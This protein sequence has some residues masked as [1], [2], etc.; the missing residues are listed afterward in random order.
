MKDQQVIP[1]LQTATLSSSADDYRDIIDD[2]TMEIQK[3]EEELKMYKQDGPELL[4]E[5]R[6]FEITIHGLPEK[7]QRE[8]RT[9]LEA[10]AAGLR[11]FPDAASPQRQC[12]GSKDAIQGHIGSGLSSKHAPS[13]LEA[14]Q[15]P[16]DSAYASISPTAISSA[17]PIGKPS[18]GAKTGLLDQNFQHHLR[19]ISEG[20]YPCPTI[21][22]DE[23]K[24]QLVVRRLEQLFSGKITGR[25]PRRVPPPSREKITH[26]LSRVTLDKQSLHHSPVHQPPV[27]INQP[28]REARMLALPQQ[29][30]SQQKNSRSK[31]TGYMSNWTGEQG[32]DN[33]SGTN[34]SP[35]DI[36][37]TEQ[38]STQPEELD[39]DRI[40]VPSENRDYI[41]H[42]GLDLPELFSGASDSI[43]P[44]HYDTEGWV[45]LNLLCNLAQLHLLNVTTNYV[46]W[47][48]SEISTNFQ[49]SP[50]GRKIR[51]RGTPEGTRSAGESLGNS[52]QESVEPGDNEVSSNKAKETCRKRQQTAQS[53]EYERQ[54]IADSSKNLSK[55]GAQLSAAS[56]SFHYKPSFV[57][58]HSFTGLTSPG[59]TL[60]SYGPTDH[61]SLGESGCGLGS[62]GTSKRRKR[63]HDGTI[64]YYSGAPFCVDLAGDRDDVS[65]TT[66]ISSSGDTR[67]ETVSMTIPASTGLT[68]G[69]SLAYKPFIAK[70]RA[71]AS[72]GVDV[73]SD[74]ALI[75]HMPWANERQYTQ[76]LPLEPSGLGGVLPGDHFIV[77]VITARSKSDAPDTSCSQVQ[78]LNTDQASFSIINRLA[79][80]SASFPVPHANRFSSLNEQRPI[81][82]IRKCPY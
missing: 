6:A 3:L 45:Y 43:Q 27:L 75:I 11:S 76:V 2:L 60:P 58:P 37:S 31:D 22:N 48:V 68:T 18:I 78:R 25:E 77:V 23:D 42:L 15:T 19:D 62:S 7:Q 63:R 79:S 5:K 81:G 50:D 65:P 16:I 53:T 13:S 41:K 56:E 38:R 8:L 30:G 34:M 35:P 73:D 52:S 14:K 64:I 49:L 21:M 46:R 72:V 67:Q 74:P 33:R 17:S 80:A 39:P 4:W 47:T 82:R 70:P 57:H 1:M 44:S 28:I 59:E 69:S 71:V 32:K 29:P 26:V 61:R 9:T 20:L 55:F 40:Q 51:W 36:H 10:F 24:K 54:P 66:Y 12:K